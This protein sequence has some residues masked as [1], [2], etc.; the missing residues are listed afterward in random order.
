[1]SGGRVLALDLDGTL[2]DCGPRQVQALDAALGGQY[3]DP[4]AFWDHK[5]R[6][7]TT[8]EALIAL[9]MHEADAHELAERWR[10]VVEADELLLAD[11]VLPGAESALEAARAH[12]E[13]LVVITAR[14]RG[15]AA[16]AQCERLGLMAHLDEV[17][18]VPPA[19]AADRKAVV[20]RDLRAIGFVGDTASDA[21]AA[22][23]AEVPF[24]AVTTGQH[25]REVLAAAVSAPIVDDLQ[26][27]I[28]V[29]TQS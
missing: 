10:V 23:A 4:V 15:D 29:L 24:A 12:A 22:A 27:A 26:T 16:A 20:L 2:L 3:R 19:E 25:T 9:G 5:R 28:R 7:L 21:R 8:R 17:I 13:R 1:M 11:T 6:G 18:A 14:R